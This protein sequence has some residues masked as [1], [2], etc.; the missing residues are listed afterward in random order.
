MSRGTLI[1]WADDTVNPVVGCDGCELWGLTSRI[2]YAGKLHEIREGRPG[3]ARDFG[4]PE[5]F[6]G[7]MRAAARAPALQGLRR[8]AKPWLDGAPRLVFASDLGDALSSDVPFEFLETEILGQ[9]SSE[10]G[11]RHRW[12]WLT[13][14]PAR[15]KKFSEWAMR[16]GWTWPSNL[17]VGTS[18]TAAANASRAAQLRGVGDD[19]TT[20]FVSFEPL[21]EPVAFTELV[22]GIDWAIIG[23][24]SGKEARRFDTTWVFDAVAACRSSNVALFVKQL[25]RNVVHAGAQL[26]LR[27]V[28]GGDW[29]EW[30]ADLRIRELPRE[31]AA[32]Q[33]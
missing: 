20:R 29:E 16:R 31:R 33:M 19:R 8:T 15:M 23:G 14:Q 4:K 21:V 6:A 18:V 24:E 22:V 11:S 9:V 17:W 27:D 13:K 1:Q 5:L 25:G 32:G 7:R 28:H 26:R 12:L 10:E 2:C 30:P 3:Y